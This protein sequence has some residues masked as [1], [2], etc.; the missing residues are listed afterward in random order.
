MAKKYIGATLTMN[1]KG[2]VDNIKSAEGSIGGLKQNMA[3]VRTSSNELE[4]GLN[5]S[6]SAAGSL[7]GELQS[8]SGS[9]I[10]ISSKADE[11]KSKL[12]QAKI[13]VEG[14]TA[15]QQRLRAEYQ[16]VTAEIAKA[17]LKQRNLTEQ[18]KS[19]KISTDEEKI[20]H[21]EIA[22]EI[23]TAAEK[24][25]N[26]RVKIAET[27]I[28]LRESKANLSVA[29]ANQSEFNAKVL[30]GKNS[31]TD[32]NKEQE[33]LKLKI[34]ESEKEQ[35]NLN[36]AYAAGAK[37]AQKA[38]KS[39]GKTGATKSNKSGS[40]AGNNIL[41]G[42][43]GKLVGAASIYGAFEGA[44]SAI[45]LSDEMSSTSARLANINDGLQTN[46]ELNQM[47]FQ[48]AKNSRG[49]YGATAELV[50]RLGANAKAAFSGTSEIVSFSEQISK[51]FVI[52]GASSDEAK[53]ATLQLSQALAS[54]A[55]RGDELNS[56]LEQAP[57]IARSIE[58]Y[59][60]VSEG[61]IK[62]LASQG[63]V[64][65]EVVKNAILST[66][67]ETN[68]TF[69][70]MP[71]TFGQMMT[72][73]K[74]TALQGSQSLL[75]VISNLWNGGDGGDVSGATNQFSQMVSGLITEISN[76]APQVLTVAGTLLSSLGAVL[77][78][79]VSQILGSISTMLPQAMT[80]GG[81]I[82]INLMQGLTAQMPTLIPTLVNGLTS[83]IES[84]AGMLPQM[85]FQGA[86]LVMNLAVGVVNS[87]PR[88][89]ETIPNMINNFMN[90]FTSNLP[91]FIGQGVHIVINLAIGLV[92]G[93]P[94]LLAAIPKM[95]IE[96]AKSLITMDW[97]KL[98]KDIWTA[99]K[100][101]FTGKSSSDSSSLGNT[102]NTDISN[103]ITSNAGITNTASF[104]LGAGATGN[105]LFG[106]SGMG[107]VG[108]NGAASYGN[109]ILSGAPF[110]NTAG[111]NV[112]QSATT[113]LI[114]G[115]AGAG[116][117]GSNA[118]NDFH[119]NFINHRENSRFA[120][121]DLGVSA[122]SGTNDG[123][124]GMNNAGLNSVQNYSQGLLNN[125]GLATNAASQMALQTAAA[126]E[127]N[128]NSTVTVTATGIPEVDAQLQG[129][130]NTGQN[131]TDKIKN[132][133]S[134]AMAE[135]KTK[136]N[137]VVSSIKSAFENMQ[138]T[139][140][141]PKIPVI[142]ITEVSTTVGTESIKTP[143]FEV[144][145]NAKGGI[146]NRP[147]VVST[148]AGLQG[149]GESGAEAVLPLD[150]LWSK[151]EQILRSEKPQSNNAAY[152]DNRKIDIHVDAR[153]RTGDEVIGDI[154]NPLKIALD[155]N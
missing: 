143:K 83:A 91:Q 30:Q 23:S 137:D 67:D 79:I 10:D 39:S 74:T 75:G 50:T 84:L 66:A 18:V 148:M 55:L 45:G 131:V 7:K 152:Y 124:F 2:L 87:I 42:I 17:E 72:K 73:M 61:S 15:E 101:G 104:N 4:T 132:A 77:P 95:F 56:V 93:I 28:S 14:T 53:N 6:S 119:T 70:K 43:G 52:A 112:G 5:S 141:K 57:N 125:S 60:G 58:T 9:N 24:Q 147:T 25:S 65:S 127:T 136:T 31:I 62:E 97:K 54:G 78:G 27:N 82:I 1:I 108:A 146:F 115:T 16:L 102:L 71:M 120:G 126:G 140:P 122:V 11:L 155:N 19:G 134:S 48:S 106:S 109:N 38:Q 121:F 98:G 145:W 150:M 34:T 94:Q 41:S 128:I 80:I 107:T 51:R 49:E 81:S 64:T 46:E 149:F 100:D 90:G 135:I 12:E 44:K 8:L 103:G 116:A 151:L 40:S 130:S 99:I 37:E 22:Q 63:L 29:K 118:A 105:L 113:G 92:K 129:L 26:L 96:F 59:M 47:I 35:K 13:V 86:L 33:K 142:S 139:I 85:I 76:A 111:Y 36:S 123:A 21:A 20:K 117:V 69:D 144:N 110:A 133:Y 153:D 3:T 154:I 68:A 89:V 138:I 32:E 114:T 88:L